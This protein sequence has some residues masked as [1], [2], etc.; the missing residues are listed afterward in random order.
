MP[1]A[2]GIAGEQ[3]A[4]RV[5]IARDHPRRKAGQTERPRAPIARPALREEAWLIKR[6]TQR[7][8]DG[9]R[10]RPRRQPGRDRNA[11]ISLIV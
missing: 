6:V 4:D 5:A 11:P 3:P 7:L 2:Q 9:R 10:P 1:P 8:D